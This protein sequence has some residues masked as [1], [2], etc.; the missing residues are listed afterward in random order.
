MVNLRFRKSDSKA[1]YNG[2]YQLGTNHPNSFCD[3]FPNLGTD[4]PSL[5]ATLF[6]SVLSEVGLRFRHR[7]LRGPAALSI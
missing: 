6:D 3:T 7:R 5:F 1:I 2:V 4:S